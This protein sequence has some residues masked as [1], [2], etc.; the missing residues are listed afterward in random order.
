MWSHP[1]PEL[2]VVLNQGIYLKPCRGFDCNISLAEEGAHSVSSA[3]SRVQGV[4]ERR[5]AAQAQQPRGLRGHRQKEQVSHALS[6]TKQNQDQDE[7]HQP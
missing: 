6:S 4:S 5:G 1:D 3:A 2:P 7:T